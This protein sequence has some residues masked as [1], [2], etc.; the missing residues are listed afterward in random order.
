M[1]VRLS[2]GGG[3]A[4]NP[5]TALMLLSAHPGRLE[6]IMERVFRIRPNRPAAPNSFQSGLMPGPP[7]PVI[8]GPIFYDHLI[9]AYLIENTRVFDIMGATIEKMVH[10]E[11]LGVASPAAQRWLRATEEL[12]FSDQPHGLISRL[13]ST[14][15]PVPSKTRR[16]A[17]SRMFGMDLNH[18]SSRQASSFQRPAISN[19]EFV[20]VFEELLREIWRGITNWSNGIGP[21]DTD[22]G[23]MAIL[24][25]ELR[26]MMR[27]RR[28]NGNLL[29]EEFYAVAT[30]SWMHLTLLVNAPIFSSLGISSTSPHERLRML[31]QRVGY[32]AHPRSES[33]LLM[34]LVLSEVLVQIEDGYYD[35]ANV[36]RFIQPGVDRS[37]LETIITH[38]SIAT[39][40][41]LKAPDVNQMPAG[42][43]AR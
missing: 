20:T 11:S 4:I 39:G 9:Y 27:E 15:R 7:I 33:F 25:F 24:V 10:D 17:Y 1:F 18:E 8:I 31:G 2:S 32:P 6:W 23:K 13:T 43:M 41:N 22:R 40:R 14:L 35:N 26:E 38:W 36:N 37:N 34:S 28:Q 19:G 3:G 16:N 30:M 21:N 12:F 29:R 42:A 5:N